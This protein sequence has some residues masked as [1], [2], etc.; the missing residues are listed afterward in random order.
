[1]S[2]DLNEGKESEEKYRGLLEAAPDAMVVVNQDGEIV[3]LNVQAEKQFGYR[4][5]ELLGQKVKNIIPEGF[6]ERLIADDLRS[7]KDALAQQ[8][9]TGIEL[10][11]RRKDGSEFPIEIM[12]SP[13]KSA[14]GIL[15]TA[16][17]RNISVR[18]TAEKH[19]AQTEARYR[20][21]LEAAP[22]AMV[23]VNQSGEIVLLNL[24]A[25]KQFGFRR[26]ELLGQKVT[27]IIPVGFAE[28]LIADDLRSAEDALAQQIG[29]GIELN[30]RRKD[31][32]EFPIEI[33]LSPLKSAEGTLVTA[34]IR[35]ITAIKFAEE[36]FRLAVESCPS[37][38]VMIDRAGKIVMVN[39]EIEALFGHPRASLIG[40]SIEILVPKKLRAQHVRRRDSYARDPECRRMGAGRDL[41]GQRKDGSEFPVEVALNPIETREGLLVLGVI[42]DISERKRIEQLK[43]EFISTVSH[44]L[45]TPLTSISASLCLLAGGADPTLSVGTKRLIAIAH[46]NTQRLVRLINDI[47]DIEKIDSCT[48][49]FNLQRVELRPLIEQAI[50]SS[51]ALADTYLVRLR[52]EVSK[53]QEVRADP[54]RL[55]QV[56]ANLLSNAI[57]F[58]PKNAEVV[59]A[60]ENHADGIRITVRDHGPGIPE[61]FRSRIF[62]KFAQA[63]ASDARQKGGTGLGLSIVKQIVLRLGGEVGFSDPPGG[64]TIFYV[65]LPRMEVAGYDNMARV[66]KFNSARI[67]LCEDDADTGAIM[68][69]RL[70]QA[71]FNTDLCRTAAD[72]IAKATITVYS[73]ILVD[74]QLSD[75]DGISLI[76]QLRAQRQHGVTPIV[77]VSANPGRGRD[78]I[79]SST[80]NVLD[81]L[82]KPLDVRRLLRT[83]RPTIARNESVRLRVLHLDNDREVLSLVAEALNDVAQ[84]VSVP[85]IKDARGALVASHF[86]LAII[87]LALDAHS[88]L[89]LLLPELRDSAGEAIPVVVYSAQGINRECA[90]QVQAA[91]TKSRASIDSL[92]AIL[93]KRITDLPVLTPDEKESV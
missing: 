21:L 45:R 64:G 29:M 93:R 77:V 56:I 54:D 20:G 62:E 7:A 76:Q 91:L 92:I 61:S 87:D 34:A 55:T 15:V 35:D 30:G 23:V 39:G 73:A 42:V 86:D 70:R 38:M 24:Q 6:A 57:K 13:L 4:R 60:V 74:L 18:K 82:N 1:M 8:I 53:A 59:V 90:A 49:A 75:S 33:M 46:S 17:I 66:E 67:L 69:D 43:D 9:G 58:S 19:L 28:R 81:W 63:D 80:L 84:V 48:V 26:D 71:G 51:R 44:E 79:R 50:E 52:F 22:D 68:C 72:A 36:K 5:D 40:E 85:T 88:G 12:L 65:K 89:E 32:S 31:G 27:S 11:G 3:L 16:A 2:H 14:E 10:N 78:D 37:G 25:E 41:F 47:L 83:L